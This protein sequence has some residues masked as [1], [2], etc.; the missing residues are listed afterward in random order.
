MT[1]G[2]DAGLARCHDCGLASR[3]A[4]V[5]A[6]SEARCSRCGSALHVRKRSSL[7]RTWALVI[8]ASIMYVPANVLPVSTVIYWG[9]GKPDTIMS[10][11]RALFAAGDVAIAVVLFVASICVPAIKLLVLTGLLL[12]I[13]LRL[14]WRPRDRT[15]LYRGIDL[16]GRWSMLDIFVISIL[17]ALVQLHEISSV[18]AG[19]GALAFCA[20]VILTLF[21]TESFDPRLMWDALEEEEA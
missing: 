5:P 21:A 11:V 16:I 8:A 19:P 2:R 6:G 1:R 18:H 12:S 9:D 7:S 17:V 10:G 20:V 13:E 14:R 4:P 15:L 3:L